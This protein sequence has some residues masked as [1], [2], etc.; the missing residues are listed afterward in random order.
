MLNIFF[1]LRHAFLC[2]GN[3][4]VRGHALVGA[5]V[6]RG[7]PTT[8]KLDLIAGLRGSG[9]RRRGGFPRHGSPVSG[10]GPQRGGFPTRQTLPVLSKRQRLLL[11]NTPRLAIADGRQAGHIRNPQ[12]CT[13]LDQVHVLIDERL[14]IGAL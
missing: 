3:A 13:R 12:R 1:Q 10:A 11:E 9:R 7:R 6:G 5:S 2:I 4:F 14:R 8:G